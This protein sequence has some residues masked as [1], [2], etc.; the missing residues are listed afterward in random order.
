VTGATKIGSISFTLLALNFALYFRFLG[1]VLSRYPQ[2]GHHSPSH[3]MKI[4]HIWHRFWPL[5][6]LPE[7]TGFWALWRIHIPLQVI[8]PSIYK[9][10]LKY[11]NMNIN[12]TIFW[13]LRI[14]FI[15]FLHIRENK[16]KKVYYFLTN[17]YRFCL[18]GFIH[19]KIFI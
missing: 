6:Y 3:F 7:P 5:T 10:R 14:Y 11:L 18:K 1:F 13:I 2:H 9:K 4:S 15:K 19:C 16:I 12:F 8:F 17:I